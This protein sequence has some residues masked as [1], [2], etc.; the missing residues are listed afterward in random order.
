MLEERRCVFVDR[1]I[2]KKCKEENCDQ[3]RYGRSARCYEHTLKREN[4]RRMNAVLKYR[5]NQ[6]EK[7]REK[8]SRKD[9]DLEEGDLSQLFEKLDE[10][11]S[12]YVRLR[13]SDEE[14]DV[15]CIS[16]DW[17]GFWEDCDCGHFFRRGLKSVRYDEDNCHAQCRSCNRFKDGNQAGYSRGLIEK[18]GVMKYGELVQRKNEVKKWVSYEIIMLHE[19]YEKK[20]KE[21]KDK[22][23]LS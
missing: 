17:K 20:V 10:V 18:I 7:R 9:F 5:K 23:N 21:L 14:G 6:L 22:K 16:C 3:P 13:D 12:K 15:V 19:Y 1:V 4:E 11:F 2:M 8:M